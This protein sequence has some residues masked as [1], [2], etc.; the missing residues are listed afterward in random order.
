MIRGEAIAKA[1]KYML[2]AEVIYCMDNLGYSP[3]EAC[4]EWD[5]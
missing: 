4:A 1:A 2:Q 5:L 3:E